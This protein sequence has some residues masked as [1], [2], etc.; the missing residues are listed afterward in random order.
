MAVCYIGIGSNLGDRR[1]YIQSALKRIRQLPSTKVTKVSV[2][3]E[4]APE[5]GPAGQG[6]YLNGVAEIETELFPYRLLAELQKIER[7]LG[8]VRVSLN[9]PR[10]LDLDILAYGELVMREVS[11][12]IPHP[13]MF[14]RAFVL[15]PLGEIAPGKAQ[16]LSRLLKGKRRTP[17]RTIRAGK[18]R[19]TGI[20]R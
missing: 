16:Q 11:L 10:T 2:L 19:T 8:R 15:E 6:H 5:G 20:R 9:G 7:D 1:F 18:K 17:G 14:V 4:S 12:S 3:R 13:R